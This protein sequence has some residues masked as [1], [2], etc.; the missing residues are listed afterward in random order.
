M[1]I[2]RRHELGALDERIDAA[3]QGGAALV[4][5]GDAGIGKSALLD[6]ARTHA[7]GRG[8]RVLTTAGVESE[9]HLPY[10]ALQR[11]L[12]PVLD[13]VEGLPESQR[14]AVRVAFGLSEGA[15]PAPFL[16]ALA[17]LHVLAEV[18]AHA[19]LLLLVDDA[20]WLDDPTAHTLAF[21]A[22]RIESDPV[23]MLIAIRDG[24]DGHPLDAALPERRLEG[25]AEAD[26]IALLDARAPGLAP[27]LRDRVLREAAGNPLAL[28]ELPIALRAAGVGDGS[29]LPSW[30]PVTRRLEQAFA[31]RL[32][33]L[34]RAT[35]TL[36]LV[37]AADEGAALGDLLL[38][39][40]EVEGCEVTLDAL[41]A[42]V[43]AGL[44]E[45]DGPRLRFR[46]PLMRSAIHETMQH[47]ERSAV[48]AALAAVARD[49]DRRV[50]HRAAAV[51]GVDATIATE[52]EDV[53]V[54]ARRRGAAAISM[55][56]LERAA[57]LAEPA[58]CGGFLVGAAELAND[59][60]RHADV[61]RLLR[62][63]ERAKLAPL[64][65][66]RLAWL[67]ELV[68]RESW[69]GA[70]RIRA[71]AEIAERMRRDGEFER[72]L[73]AL[74]AV[75]LRCWWSNPD[76]ETRRRMVAVAERLPFPEDEP[77][78]LAI[79]GLA[80]PV[81]RGAVVIER[82]ARLTLDP[83]ASASHVLLLAHGTAGV[84]ACAEAQR[85]LDVAIPGLRAQ[86]Q[87]GLL[88]QA[89]VTQAWTAIRRGRWRLAGSAAREGNRLAQET[90]QPLWVT[91]AEL[92]EATLAAYRGEIDTAERLAASGEKLLLPIGANPML[93]LVQFPRGAAALATGRHAEAYEHL[94][95]IFDPAD[96]AFQPL[97]RSW[98]LIDLVEAAVHA[99]RIDEARQIV[100]ELEPLARETQSP[101]LRAALD[102]AAPLLAP[103]EHADALFAT[104]LG[105]RLIDWP[106]ARGRLALAYGVW[107]RRQRRVADSRGPLRAAR[108]AFDA[109]DAAPWAERAR[110]ELRASGETSRSRTR[111]LADTLSPQELQIAQM[112][113]EGLSNKAIGSQLFLSHRTVA[114]HLYRVF[115]KLG[116][117]ARSQLR[118]ALE[119][120]ASR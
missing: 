4:L 90:A 33:A 91:V 82:L 74:S 112:A 77:R 71:F 47:L 68:E 95:R 25:L 51:I 117:A 54:R 85:I 118:G 10:A 5:R 27:A 69:S 60:G 24:V 94:A 26:A 58:R 116:I 83:G 50:W 67:R 20:Q 73:D 98:V 8:F 1:L 13:A 110:Q 11:L 78:L 41:P 57:Q 120:R 111:A 23:V 19:P 12:H 113:A 66:T 14:T 105:P 21:L 114:S 29:T 80:G 96:V 89:L 35:R 42:A 103:D 15:A 48:H 18:A 40:S 109:L 115:P 107:L 79:L 93:A 36:L 55:E 34:P 86:G 6:E 30:L 84:G 119:D 101:L 31:T 70:A 63:A 87:L 16:L 104:S 7:I 75:A 81:E 3:S 53:A 45:I 37:A 64:D 97:V 59:L 44:V 108:D 56:A 106:F 2:G 9:S 76:E 102:Y 62:A 22:R 72:A 100:A 65:Q 99:D 28:V 49:P 46:H 52:L 39:A 38:A 92:A 17:V 88:A 32:S 61:A 43:A